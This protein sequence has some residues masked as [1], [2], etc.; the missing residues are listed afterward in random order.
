M[1]TENSFQLCNACESRMRTSCLSR[2]RSC[3]NRTIIFILYMLDIVQVEL[4]CMLKL[5]DILYYI[6]IM[7]GMDYPMDIIYLK[8]LTYV[9][10][11]LQIPQII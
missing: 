10:R 11:L 8:S 6:V 9:I 3:S 7:V 1:G 5:K 2:L 4:Q